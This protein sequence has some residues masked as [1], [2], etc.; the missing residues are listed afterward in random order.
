MAAPATATAKMMIRITPRR[1]IF[2]NRHRTTCIRESATFEGIAYQRKFVGQN[3]LGYTLN[4]TIANFC[5]CGFAVCYAE[6]L[7]FSDEEFLLRIARLRL[8]VPGVAQ[9]SNC[10][11]AGAFPHSRAAQS[12]RR[13][14]HSSSRTVSNVTGFLLGFNNKRLWLHQKPSLARSKICATKFVITTSSITHTPIR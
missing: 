5:M 14:H 2:I 10:I 3:R 9:E 4:G 1:E 8:A 13:R 6:N 12:Q 11:K 7:W